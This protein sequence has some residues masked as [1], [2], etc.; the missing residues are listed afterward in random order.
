MGIERLAMRYLK[1][2]AAFVAI[3]IGLATV[4]LY[5]MPE[6]A[7][8]TFLNVDRLR[9]G[10]VEREIDLANGL[11]ISY[12]EGG[13]GKKLV[14]LHGFGA[15]KDNFARVSRYLTPHYHVI[16]P[17]LIGFGESSK[18]DEG[19]YSPVAQAKNLKAFFEALQIKEFHLGGSSMGGQISMTYADLYPAE[20]LSLWLIDT[21]GIPSAPQSELSKA[22]VETGINPL[23]ANSKEEFHKLYQFVMSDPPFVPGPMLDVLARKRQNN[24]ALEQKI[25]PQF[26]SISAEEIAS[27]LEMPTLIMWGEEDRAIHVGA[28]E[29]L[30]K[31]IPHSEVVVMK[32]V[33]HLPMLERPY[34]AA[35][36]F[37]KFQNRKF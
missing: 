5:G 26:A 27:G 2:S 12:L 31:L 13:K 8:N 37:L 28:T 18:P 34:Q 1:W 30:K 35:E 11:H 23:T 25:F 10:L 22:I 19:V 7:L 17:D 4:F 16:V 9:A 6:T 3:V 24:F 21:A 36:D 15:D 32:G 20:V 33:G 14:L 29:V